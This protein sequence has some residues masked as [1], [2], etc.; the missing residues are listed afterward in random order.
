MG[1]KNPIQSLKYAS[2]E[3]LGCGEE[4]W[5]ATPRLY[6]ML[7]SRRVLDVHFIVLSLRIIAKV[8]D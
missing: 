5:I 3:S 2:E 1:S 6:F 7:T 4:L 8:R